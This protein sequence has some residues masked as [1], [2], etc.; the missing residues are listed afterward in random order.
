MCHVVE[1]TPTVSFIRSFDQVHVCSGTDKIITHCKICYL[2]SLGWSLFP[3]IS[4]VL[5]HVCC[6]LIHNLN[7][8]LSWSTLRSLINIRVINVETLFLI[9]P[10]LLGLNHSLHLFLMYVAKIKV[11]SPEM[12]TLFKLGVIF[13]FR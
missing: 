7:T 6:P 5:N 8:V 9:N 4:T 2:D 13:K 12:F 1:L 3:R 11:L 10:N